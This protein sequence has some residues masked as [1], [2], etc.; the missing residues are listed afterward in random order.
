MKQHS[1]LTVLEFNG[2]TIRVSR[3]AIFKK[4]RMLTHCFSFEVGDHKKNAARMIFREMKK[5]WVMQGLK[6]IVVCWIWATASMIK[7]RWIFRHGSSTGNSAQVLHD[8]PHPLGSFLAFLQRS[9]R[10]AKQGCAFFGSRGVHGNGREIIL[11]LMQVGII[12]LSISSGSK[13]ITIAW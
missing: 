12:N 2:T 10:L 13:N 1:P 8:V 3:S 6:H 9:A 7:R 4:R 11:Y 5:K